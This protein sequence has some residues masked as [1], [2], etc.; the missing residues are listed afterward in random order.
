MLRCRYLGNYAW[1]WE[2]Q[3]AFLI[4]PNFEING[5]NW[6]VIYIRFLPTRTLDASDDLRVVKIPSVGLQNIP[7]YQKLQYKSKS[8]LTV[9]P[10]FS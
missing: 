4:S 9:L 5:V 1:V 7:V 2:T 8:Q 3:A 6:V 10:L